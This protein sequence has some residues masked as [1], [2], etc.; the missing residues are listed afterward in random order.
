MDE[1]KLSDAD[2]KPTTSAENEILTEEASTEQSLDLTKAPIHNLTPEEQ[3]PEKPPR[4]HRI[5]AKEEKSTKIGTTGFSSS[6]FHFVPK[7]LKQGMKMN[8]CTM[9]YLILTLSVLALSS[10]MANIVC[11]N[12][13]VL[14]MPATDEPWN[15]N[16]TYTGYSK[17]EKTWLFSSV[18]VGA[19]FA[20]VPVSLSI[21][22]FGTR[23]VFFFAGVLSALA[24]LFTPL[25]ARS[26]IV[27]FVAMRFLLGI[28]FSACMPTVGAIT[29]TWSPL[30]QSGLFMSALTAFGQL[31]AVFS[32]PV[33]GHLCASTL[34]WCSVFYL[35]GAL[36]LLI[37]TMWFLLYRDDPEDLSLM[38]KREIAEIQSGKDYK[39]EEKKEDLS[40]NA[41]SG[42]HISG[43]SSEKH[44]KVPYLE[45]ASTPSVWGVWAGAL[46]DLIAVQLIHTFSPFYIKTVLEYSMEKTGWTSAL[47]VLFQFLVKVIAGHSSDRIH[48]FSETTKL[49]VF[50]SVAL[51]VSAVFMTALAFLPKGHSM[52][53]ITLLTLT[54]AMFGFNGGGFN[55]CAAL[56]SRQYSHFVLANIQFLWCLAMLICPVLVG[57]LLHTGSLAE[58]RLV[59]LIHAAILVITNLIFCFLATAKPAT[60]TDRSI[61]NVSKRRTPVLHLAA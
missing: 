35:H 45:I 38:S 31:S 17:D 10:I 49:R 12:F 6:D 25:A 7:Q 3:I 15:A 5:T 13:T 33:S 30:A 18:A 26:H 58:W 29:S 20:V 39:Q 23:K 11:F 48:G 28:S 59:Y 43:K 1:I 44:G 34:G 40:F 57:F 14:C 2:Q 51:G 53:G 9:R 54:T 37:F 22:R 56:V 16:H 41:Q 27:F 60:W 61:Q 21:T 24:T 46:G 42:S 32:M 50:N 55:K 47:P 36:G 52:L 19:L 4:K 8:G